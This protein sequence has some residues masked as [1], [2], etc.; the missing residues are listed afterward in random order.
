MSD[1]PLPSSQ[2]RHQGGRGPSNADDGIRALSQARLARARR[3]EKHRQNPGLKKKLAFMT[4][5]LKSLDLLVFAE[6]SAMYYM[7]FVTPRH[8]SYQM[9]S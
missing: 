3:K 2:A 8:Q 6:L 4:H 5:L 1:E 9:P 7:E